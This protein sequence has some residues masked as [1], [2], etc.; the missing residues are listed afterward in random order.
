MP[1]KRESSNFQ[2]WLQSRIDNKMKAFLVGLENLGNECL[3][4]MRDPQKRKYFDRT[5]NLRSSTGWM[6]VYNGVIYKS[7]GFAPVTSPEGNTGNEGA[8]TGEDLAKEVASHEVGSDGV[9]LILVAGMNY[10]VYVERM[11]LNVLDSAKLYASAEVKDLINDL[12]K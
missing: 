6:I 11:A 9:A 1:I 7:S 2:D 10:A 4:E 12:L 5:A 8:K 3:V